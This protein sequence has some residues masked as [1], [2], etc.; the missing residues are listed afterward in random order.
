MMDEETWLNADEAVAI[1]FATGISER[2][3]EKNLVKAA[4]WKNPGFNKI[5]TGMAA[6]FLPQ[7]SK[8]FKNSVQTHETI[9]N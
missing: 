4:L 6:M 5:P 8:S 1:G 3:E 9:I 2:T 7:E